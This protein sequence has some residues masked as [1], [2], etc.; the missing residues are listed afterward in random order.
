MVLASLWSLFVI[1][2]IILSFKDQPGSSP[3]P[4]DDGSP[5]A[6]V[7]ALVV[8]GIAIVAQWWR[9]LFGMS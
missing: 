3:R 9:L 1:V 7:I 4:T 5:V 8:T 6:L 2:P